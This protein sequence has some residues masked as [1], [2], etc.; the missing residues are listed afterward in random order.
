ML[1][2]RSFLQRSNGENENM[3]EQPRQIT[4]PEFGLTLYNYAISVLLKDNLYILHQLHFDI[5]NDLL[6]FTTCNSGLKE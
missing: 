1:I 5:E 3:G 2:L 6:P 4:I